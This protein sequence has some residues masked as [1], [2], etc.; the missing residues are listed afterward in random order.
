[1]TKKTI[2][3]KVVDTFGIK[4]EKNIPVP[5]PGGR[6]EYLEKFKIVLNYLTPGESFLIPDAVHEKTKHFACYVSKINVE[7][8]K[9]ESGRF[10][11]TRKVEGG[12]RV[13]RFK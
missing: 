13:W 12:R 9:F 1:M 8:R 7:E 10:F 3:K 6:N 2:S 5:T 11:V 4:I